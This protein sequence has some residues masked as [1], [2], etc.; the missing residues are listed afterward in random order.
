LYRRQASSS[1]ERAAKLFAELDKANG[2]KQIFFL[3]FFLKIFEIK[4][5]FSASFILFIKNKT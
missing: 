4:I 5:S 3:F 1:R 2:N